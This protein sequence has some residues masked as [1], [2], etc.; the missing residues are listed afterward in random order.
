MKLQSVAIFVLFLSLFVSVFSDTAR[1]GDWTPIKNLNDPFVQ[2]IA[3]IL[4]KEH[5]KQSDEKLSLVA[6]VRGESQDGA[7]TNYRLVLEAKDE[8]AATNIYEAIFWDKSFTHFKNLVS[9]KKTY[10]ILLFY[11][12]I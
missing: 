4:L 6:V 3:Q 9:F 1:T 5:E 8:S 10:L 2:E 11:N 7:G 12:I